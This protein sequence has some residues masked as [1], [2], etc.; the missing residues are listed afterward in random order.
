LNPLAPILANVAVPML[1]P[2]PWLMVLA[3]GPVVGVEFAILRRPLPIRLGHVLAANLVSTLCGLPV[4][5]CSLG[6][7]GMLLGNTDPNWAHLGWSNRLVTHELHNW[8]IL[9]AA[10][11]AVVIPCFL[12]SVLVE[13]WFLAWRVKLSG[14]AELWSPLVRAHAFSY[15]LLLAV[16]CLW[17]WLKLPR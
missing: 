12:V 9:P 14:S 4:A 11:I 7:F 13:G 10:M 2:Q 1:F 5:W 6:V 8:W 3:L 15:L 17:F 16:D